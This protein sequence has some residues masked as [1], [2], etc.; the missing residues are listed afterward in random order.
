[1]FSAKAD[2]RRLPLKGGFM[3]TDEIRYRMMLAVDGSE[4]FLVIV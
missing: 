2:N 1:M 3:M 4:N